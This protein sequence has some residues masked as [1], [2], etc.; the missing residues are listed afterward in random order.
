[1]SKL[2]VKRESS[3]RNLKIDNDDKRLQIPFTRCK[4]YADR[5]FSVYGPKIWNDLPYEI[6]ASVNLESFKKALKAYYF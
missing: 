5:S 3:N 4:T 1:M 2:I 6:R